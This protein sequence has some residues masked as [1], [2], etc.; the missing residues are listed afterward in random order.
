MGAAGDAD[1]QLDGA[2]GRLVRKSDTERSGRGPVILSRKRAILMNEAEQQNL[3]EEFGI[4]SLA[5]GHERI[6]EIP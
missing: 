3:P 4:K 5:D 2:A 1:R 6:A